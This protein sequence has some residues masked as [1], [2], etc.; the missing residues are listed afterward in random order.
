MTQSSNARTFTAD[1]FDLTGYDAVQLTFV[2]DHRLVLVSRYPK[3]VVALFHAPR[4]VGWM[5]QNDTMRSAT[6]DTCTLVSC[7]VEAVQRY[8]T[9]YQGQLNRQRVDSNDHLLWKAVRQSC[10]LR[11]NTSA[12]SVA[13]NTSTAATTT[14]TTAD[15]TNAST[16][17]TEH[18]GAQPHTTAT[19]PSTEDTVDDTNATDNKGTTTHDD[20]SVRDN[21]EASVLQRVHKTLKPYHYWKDTSMPMVEIDVRAPV[22]QPHLYQQYRRR[23]RKKASPQQHQDTHVTREA[24]RPHANALPPVRQHQSRVISL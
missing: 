22:H 18:D 20:D 23:T 2:C 10:T 24:E 21:H 16:T 14:T 15:A 5:K 9:D 8:T 17:I 11:A 7:I 12:A 19:T 1:D 4:F 13:T 3:L 6:C